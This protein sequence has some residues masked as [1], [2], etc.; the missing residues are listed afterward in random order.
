VSSRGSSSSF[1]VGIL[2]VSEDLRRAVEDEGEDVE[3]LSPRVDASVGLRVF[4]MRDERA[5]VAWKDIMLTQDSG[6]QEPQNDEAKG[7]DGF[8]TRR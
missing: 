7:M 5:G 8:A 4:V 6:I 3:R 2:V 1:C